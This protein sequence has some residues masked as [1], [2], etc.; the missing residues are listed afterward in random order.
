MSGVTQIIE[1]FIVVA[2][3]DDVIILNDKFET[4]MT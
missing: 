2:L 1:I 4:R 3:N